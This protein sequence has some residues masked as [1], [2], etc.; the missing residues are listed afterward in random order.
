V[1]LYAFVALFFR[2]DW[3]FRLPLNVLLVNDSIAFVAGLICW[4]IARWVVLKN[5]VRYPGLA[6]TRQ[7]LLWLL[8]ALPILVSGAWFLRHTV[9][10]LL[11]GNFLLFGSGVELSRTI[12]I[13]IFY[14]FIYFSIYEGWYILRQWK[15][16]TVETNTLEKVSLQS[17][18]DALQQQVNPHFLF[19]S[20]N[21]LSSLI[22]E[23]PDRADA[24]LDELTSVF[25]YLLQANNRELVALRDELDFVRSYVYLLQTR[26]QSGLVF[27]VSTDTTDDLDSL[28]IPPL[29]LQVLI[30]NALRYNVILPD[31]PL[32]I[33]ISTGTDGRLHVSNTLQRKP[34]RVATAGSG[35][36]N[37]SIRYEL[38][39]QDKLVITEETDWFTV[40]LPLV[41]EGQLTELG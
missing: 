30:E 16:E 18:L 39:S 11:Y 10:F 27:D 21:S 14:H 24:F 9:R 33:R 38:L 5:Q 4:Q 13:Q 25:R 6:N 2:L 1:G 29:T 23:D 32:H 3:Y 35:L 37:L 19:N 28:L 20:L 36:T 15:R 7:R 34:L 40:S 17:Q 41:R 26:Y 12:G 22:S 8:M 31:Q